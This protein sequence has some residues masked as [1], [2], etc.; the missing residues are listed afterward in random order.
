MLREQH[1]S[2]PVGGKEPGDLGQVRRQVRLEQ[3]E[4]ERGTG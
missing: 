4:R 1:K 3:R 2:R